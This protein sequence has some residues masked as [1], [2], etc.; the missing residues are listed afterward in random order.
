MLREV[1]RQ[2]QPDVIVCTYLFYQGILS[3]VFAIE[4]RHFPLLTVVT[5]LET[6]Q[7]LW[8]HPAVDLCLVPTQVVYDL[9]I[10]AGLPPQKVKITRIP[11]RPELVKGNQDQASLRQSLG[12][13]PDL[14][15]VLAVGSKRVEHLYDALRVLNHSGLPL[16]LV[17][18]AGGDDE[19]FQRFQE[20]EW[21]V[22]THCHNFVTEMGTF[23]RAA[24][25]ILGKAGG[26]TVS[27]ALACGL[28]LILIDVIPGQETGNANHVVSGNAGTLARDPIE[29]L[30]T[31]CHWLENDRLRYH[32]QAEN[33]RQLGHPR[34]AYDVADLAWA[35]TSS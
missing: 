22:E 3:A 27:D 4:K 11:I 2:K 12:W 16:Q 28:P 29:V 21:H 1:I 30:E 9:A 26:L 31:M 34:A 33:A 5:D 24:D 20:T 18:G 8:F 23:M 13:R 35:V 32:Q 10:A 6:V 7:S 17:V 15:T 19:L 14:F 25:C